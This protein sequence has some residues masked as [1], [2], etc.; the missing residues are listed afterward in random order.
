MQELLNCKAGALGIEIVLPTATSAPQARVYLSGA[1]QNPGVYAVE[2][3]DRLVGGGLRRG[4]ER[5]L[6]EFHELRLGHVADELTDDL[7][8]LCQADRI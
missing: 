4:L 3:G 8:V 6:D 2:E 5:L 7:A 1:V